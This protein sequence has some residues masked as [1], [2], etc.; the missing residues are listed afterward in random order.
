MTKNLKFLTLFFSFTL[1]L[2][3]F[4]ILYLSTGS[5]INYVGVAIAAG[6]SLCGVGV[7]VVTLSMRADAWL[8]GVESKVLPAS[9]DLRVG[10]GLAI[11]FWGWALSEHLSPDARPSGRGRFILGPIYDIAGQ[12][13]LVASGLI[14]GLFF[15]L[16]GVLN[17]YKKK[18]LRKLRL[19]T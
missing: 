16:L 8:D 1:L 11:I 12:D 4:A 9:L 5:H 6:F 13:G 14:I 3:G 2:V 18:D 19:N 15:I 10:M 17:A 7:A